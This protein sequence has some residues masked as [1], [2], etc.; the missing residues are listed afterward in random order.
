MSI[1]YQVKDLHEEYSRV[2]GKMESMMTKGLRAI[3]IAFI[4]SQTLTSPLW[5]QDIKTLTVLKPWTKDA[6]VNDSFEAERR[7]WLAQ[8]RALKK[9]HEES[10][11]DGFLIAGLSKEQG[12]P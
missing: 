7:A 4:L 9:K 6:S 1:S 12:L 8:I 5:A 3:V 11:K 2:Q 10:Q